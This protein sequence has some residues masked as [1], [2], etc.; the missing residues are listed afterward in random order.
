[1]E[2]LHEN[3]TKIYHSTELRIYEYIYELILESAAIVIYHYEKH[4]IF[5]VSTKNFRLQ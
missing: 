3:S 2:I 1:M 5:D 4:S